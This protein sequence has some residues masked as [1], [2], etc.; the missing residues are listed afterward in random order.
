MF[1]RTK[2]YV[3]RFIHLSHQQSYNMFY[4]KFILYILSKLLIKRKKGWR[5]P[6]N[7]IL[8]QQNWI[9]LTR[10]HMFVVTK[11]VK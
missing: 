10:R 1:M 4:I 6:G 8:L 9:L 11:Y 7:E 3:Y 5:E 2:A